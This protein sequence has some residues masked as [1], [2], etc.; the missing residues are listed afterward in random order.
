[1]QMIETPTAWRVMSGVK[2]KDGILNPINTTAGKVNANIGSDIIDGE[3]KIAWVDYPKDRFR[4]SDVVDENGNV[5]ADVQNQI[6]H[7]NVCKGINRFKANMTTKPQQNGQNSDLVVSPAL[8]STPVVS[9]SPIQSPPP[10]VVS[11]AGG[12]PKYVPFIA[13]VATKVGCKKLGRITINTIASLL[14]DVAAGTSADPGNRAAWR[15]L[16]DNL[17]DQIGICNENDVM[18]LKNEVG[19]MYDSY[20]ADGNLVKAVRKGFFRTAEDL[21]DRGVEVTKDKTTQTQSVY[22]IRRLG[23]R[24][25]LE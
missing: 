18:Q 7:C 5:D 4:R 1:M 19:D 14:A 17:I 24:S 15:R 8:E 11:F 25:G 2:V 9:V 3:H 23:P 20:Q 22:S 16:S 13:D 12:F 21:L 10:E 6:E